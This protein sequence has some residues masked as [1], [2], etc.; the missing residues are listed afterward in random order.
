[1]ENQTKRKRV[2][3]WSSSSSYG[4]VG[5]YKVNGDPLLL[6]NFK[7]EYGGECFPIDTSG[8]MVRTPGE[9]WAETDA[10]IAKNS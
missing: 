9:T 5:K 3:I 1:M 7:S 2:A 6:Y 4:E 10:M 8:N